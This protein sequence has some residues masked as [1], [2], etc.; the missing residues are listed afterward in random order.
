[1]HKT[2]K[3]IYAIK[4][5][6]G[7][8]GNGVAWLVS[9]FLALLHGREIC[10]GLVHW[11]PAYPIRIDSYESWMLR[12]IRIDW[13]GRQQHWQ[14]ANQQASLNFTYCQSSQLPTC[15]TVY[16]RCTT[17]NLRHQFWRFQVSTILIFLFLLIY[18]FHDIDIS[19]HYIWYY[20]S[21]YRTS[22]VLSYLHDIIYSYILCDIIYDIIV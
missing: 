2:I 1:M 9:E 4:D 21:I 22:Y 19:H 20:T 6:I 15:K 3:R 7:A 14:Q 17:S 5:L 16:V 11:Q 12:L 8:A 18:H 10:T 13:L